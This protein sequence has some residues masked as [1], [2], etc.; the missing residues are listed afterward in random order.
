MTE[1]D[2]ENKKAQCANC[3]TMYRDASRTL[4]R[5]FNQPYLVVFAC[6]E[7]MNNHPPVKMHNSESDISYS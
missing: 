5:Q 1:N 7:M 6:L 3:G 2:E 4:E